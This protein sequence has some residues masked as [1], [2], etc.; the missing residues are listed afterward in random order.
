[1]NTV[2]LL[3]VLEGIRI[4]LSACSTM[5]AN[6]VSLP[7]RV[8]ANDG[9]P[10]LGGPRTTSASASLFTLLGG[11]EGTDVDTEEGGEENDGLA[12]VKAVCLRG[13]GRRFAGC[14]VTPGEVLGGSMD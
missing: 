10:C 5:F 8:G 11:G 6:W 13:T 9:L 3:L 4:P 14:V 2:T 12:I 7:W 1:L